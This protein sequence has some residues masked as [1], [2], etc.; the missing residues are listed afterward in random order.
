MRV[1]MAAGERSGD[2]HAAGLLHALRG[3]R[4]DLV[5]E[6]VGGP[7]LASAGASLVARAESLAA[8]GFTEPIWR[9]ARHVRLLREI[10]E[11]FRRRAYDL[12]ILVDYPGFNLRLARAASR[13]GLPVLYYIAPQAWAWAEGRARTLAR[14]VRR[15]AVVLP[16]EEAF[17]AARGVNATY[18]GHPLLDQDYPN[19]AT[20]RTLLG[21]DPAAS[22]LALLPGSR[23]AEVRRLWPLMREAARLLK[24]RRPGLE[25]VLAGVATCRYPRSADVGARIVREASAS[26]LAAADVLWCKAGTTTLEAAIVDV[27]A[28]TLYRTDPLSYAI[29]RRV[30]RVPYVNLANLL[31]GQA[32]VPELIQRQARTATLLELTLPLLAAGSPEARAQREA[33]QAVRSQLG[34]GGAAQR[35]AELA[36]Q[37]VA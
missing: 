36:L 29:A 17:F 28:V 4:P 37:L 12:V 15:L 27:P 8:T 2:R 14:W 33:Y 9:L 31:V 16:F 30:V 11:R 22:V 1:F 13:S 5:V 25:I 26:V 23:P 10:G 35:T 7:A 6:G 34:P 18:V 3:R 21:L 19:R 32:V 20:A 24:R